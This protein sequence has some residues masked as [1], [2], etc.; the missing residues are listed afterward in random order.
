M[1]AADRLLAYDVP[2]GGCV[3]GTGGKLVR[4]WNHR[5]EG[6]RGERRKLA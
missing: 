2:W 6:G 1:T 3:K 4:R 5:S